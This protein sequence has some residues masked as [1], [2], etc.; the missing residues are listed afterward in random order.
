MLWSQLKICVFMLIQRLAAILYNSDIF[1]CYNRVVW[2]LIKSMRLFL[3]ETS[4]NHKPTLI[5]DRNHSFIFRLPTPQSALIHRINLAHDTY[6]VDSP[7]PLESLYFW[8]GQKTE[9]LGFD[10]LIIRNLSDISL[11]VKHQT[12][13]ILN[14]CKFLVGNLHSAVGPKIDSSLLNYGLKP[15][16]SVLEE[17]C[18]NLSAM[19]VHQINIQEIAL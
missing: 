7:S 5:H 16:D 8:H 13:I 9:A 3:P 6:Y 15:V 14:R 17:S 19:L 18:L 12:E 2:K 10:R 1:E 11:F 4:L